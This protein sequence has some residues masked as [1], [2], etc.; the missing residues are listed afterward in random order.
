MEF[1]SKQPT[2]HSV[3]DIAAT[4]EDDFLNDQADFYAVVEELWLHLCHR[5]PL[6]VKMT[7]MVRSLSLDLLECR[8]PKKSPEF[9]INYCTYC[10]LYHRIKKTAEK[11]DRKYQVKSYTALQFYQFAHGQWF[12][13]PEVLM[14]LLVDLKNNTEFTNP[15]YN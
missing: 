15:H 6:S 3:A 2:R 7:R 10:C 1:F 5:L 13:N 4:L 9:G 11:I 8:F 14:A 12:L